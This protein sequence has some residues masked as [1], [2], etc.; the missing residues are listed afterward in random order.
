LSK[1]NLRT[2]VSI[3]EPSAG[4]RRADRVALML[5]NIPQF[6]VAYFGIL[7]AGGVVVPT[8]PLYTQ[9]EL[10]Q[11]LSD[12]Q[13]TAIVTL[14]QFFGRVQAA[15][16]YTQISKVVVA[17]IGQALPRH[18]QPLYG[19]KQW[20]EG[21]HAVRRGD[22]VHRF[23]DLLGG[24]RSPAPTDATPADLAVLQYTGGTTGRAK[25]AMLSHRNLVV[26]AVQAFHWQS[27]PASED[28]TVLCVAP[29]FHVYGMTIGM[30]LSILNGATM[31]LVPRF[32]PK[33]V[34][35]IAQKYK[36]QLF[37]GVPTMYV[38]LSELPDFSEQPDRPPRP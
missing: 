26:N 24:A 9:R 13:A 36:P 33:E 23:E 4:L 5:P 29:F 11:Q 20:R 18:I 38:A 1:R 27:D 12:A 17:G 37:P 21:V 19:L 32:T 22:V 35:G 28:L 25:G 7:K 30:N 16:P 8:N 2:G 14:D 3:A 6:V 15:L 31:L 10:E 34:A